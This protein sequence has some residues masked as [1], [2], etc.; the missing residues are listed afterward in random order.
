MTSEISKTFFDQKCFI[1]VCFHDNVEK[2]EQETITG[3]DG[4]PGTNWKL[5]YRVSKLRYDQDT[6]KGLC[7]TY[8]V[9]FNN[10]VIKFLV[11]PEFKKFVADT[12][13]DGI[14]NVL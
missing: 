14:H 3:P 10:D 13:I 12:A 8:D 7:S 6:R 2:P 1:N 11:H 4:K 5:P 9:V